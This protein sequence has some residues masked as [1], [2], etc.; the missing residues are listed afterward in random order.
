L[1]SNSASSFLRLNKSQI[2]QFDP[3]FPRTGR[4]II[5]SNGN[6]VRLPDPTAFEVAVDDLLLRVPPGAFEAAADATTATTKIPD[7]FVFGE[8]GMGW[9]GGFQIGP[10]G[11]VAALSSAVHA[12]EVNFLGPATVSR[13]VADLDPEVYLGIVLQNAGDPSLRLPDD[14]RPSEWLHQ[15]FPNAERGALLDLPGYPSPSL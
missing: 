1:S 4:R 13:L 6:M 12:F 15:N 7:N 14:V 9:D 3:R 8:G 2:D 11:G 10:F 5:D